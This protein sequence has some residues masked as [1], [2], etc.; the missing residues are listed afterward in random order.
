MRTVAL[1][2]LAVVLALTAGRAGAAPA[3]SPLTDTTR[4]PVA[5]WAMPASTAPAFAALGVNVFVGDQGA[6]KGWCDTLAANGCV[7]F[8]GWRSRRSA[9]QRQ[10][11]ASSPGFLGWMH[12]DEPDNPDVVDDVFMPYHVL[13]SRLLADY[14][15]MRTSTTPAPMY[16]N[17]G[18]GLA[19]GMAQS[20]PDSV[21]PA[22]CA[23][24]DVVCYDVYPT[25]TQDDG[26]NRLHLVARGV[27]RL[28]AFAGPAKPVWIWLECTRIDGER[29][30][31]GRRCPLPYELRAEVWLSILY[32]ADGIG[33][34][35]H[36]FNPYRGGPA[37][38][39]EPV[40]AE[41]RLTNGLLQRLAPVLR[42]G[43][44]QVLAVNAQAG[45]VAAVSWRFGE[46]QLV[47][48]VNMG[49][50]AAR[51]AVAL[52]PDS[53]RL[54]PLGGSACPPGP[55][56]S[57]PASLQP[58]EVRL[59]GAGI[60]LGGISYRYPAPPDPQWAAD[61]AVGSTGGSV[62]PLA[63]LPA[64]TAANASRAWAR[65]HQTRLAVPAL[66]HAPRLDGVLDEAAWAT[67]ARLGTWVQLGG[68]RP[69]VAATLGWIGQFDGT[70]YL[71]FR[72]Q[73]A[74]LDSL[75]SRYAAAWRNDCVEV[76]FDP[77]NRRTS[78]AHL[79]ITADGRVE[80]SRTVQDAWAEGRRDDAWAPVV[81]CRTG[82]EAGSWTAEL[83]VPLAD[84]GVRSERSVIAFDAARE[85]QPGGGENSVWTTGGFNQACYF[86]ELELNPQPLT[87]ADGA[88]ANCGPAP[89]TARV[90]ALISSRRDSSWVPTWESQWQ[91]LGRD[92]L[93]V[94]VPGATESGPGRVELVNPETASRVPP[95]GR[96]RWVLLGPGAPQ[97]EEWVA[98]PAAP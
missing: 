27:E 72:A 5:V 97:Q 6:A 54:T 53:D 28:R 59:Y 34:F 77:D 49:S 98:L 8:V 7:G 63:A 92:T 85:R 67:A 2:T 21:Y 38:I 14:R 64:C 23:S 33:Y 76:W 10:A 93:T 19:N 57:L 70:L 94:A 71:A 40:Q 90:E 73:E 88:L 96:L 29:S 1:A 66:G 95:G 80:A 50:E 31:T 62:G 52:P 26:V 69:P 82:R 39:P 42:Q 89:V 51:A 35:P 41:M 12:G 75:V 84:L 30:G 20:T 17:L 36:Q 15:E 74:Q 3:V 11:I 45:R 48:V 61:R 56:G 86:G 68:A 13:P 91:S 81:T 47:A 44:R 43:Q 22:F 4:Y 46:R 18:Q 37:A 65:T 25:S 16:L 55:P 58:Y 83:A 32:G 60:D 9:A 24:A 78:F 79:V 87:L